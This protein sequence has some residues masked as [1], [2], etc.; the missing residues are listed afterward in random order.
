MSARTPDVE[1]W[2]HPSADT[3]LAVI[4]GATILFS[5]TAFIAGQLGALPGTASTVIVMVGMGVLLRVTWA[6]VSRSA[7]SAART[8]MTMMISSV[9]LAISTL[10]L[11]AALPRLTKAGGMEL[12]LT[13]LAAQLWTIALL[14]VAAHPVRSFG[15][16]VFAGAFLTGFLGL[17]ALARFLARWLVAKLGTSSLLA[18]G[19]WVP[20]TEEACKMLPVLF[21]LGWALRRA[22]SRQSLLDLVLLAA[23]SGAG[24]AVYENASYGRGGFSLSANGL[25]SLVF[26]SSGKGSAFGWSVMQ[27][28]HLLHSALIALGVGFAFLYGRR[29]RRPWIIPAVAIGAVLLEHISQNSMSVG[30]LNSMLAEATLVLSLGGRLCALLLIAGVG[31]VA[32]IEWRAAP[33]KA[34]AHSPD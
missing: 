7:A 12:M 16:R 21:A 10:T 13:D 30:G 32:A 34:R 18:V 17:T 15:W 1:W 11:L 9:G 4:G 24:F 25:L 2:S 3:R 27:T 23:W 19:I 29:M 22:G 31:C 28:G 14:T 26:P 33:A 6:Y 5:L 8:R 20:L